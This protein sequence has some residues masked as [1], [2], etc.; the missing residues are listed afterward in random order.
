MSA[1]E[2]KMIDL[3]LLKAVAAGAE[4]PPTVRHAVDVLCSSRLLQVEEHAMSTVMPGVYALV[5]VRKGEG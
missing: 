4:L 3:D 5:K 1:K 2:E